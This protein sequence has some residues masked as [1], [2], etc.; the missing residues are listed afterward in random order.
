M[1]NAQ[2]LVYILVHYKCMFLHSLDYDNQ[3]YY[4]IKKY[5]IN[6]FA[7]IPCNWL[8]YPLHSKP[9]YRTTIGVVT[10]LSVWLQKV[11]QYNT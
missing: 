10:D 2:K 9:V 4:L 8:I 7:I 11:T 1:M 3:Y 5:L 6:V